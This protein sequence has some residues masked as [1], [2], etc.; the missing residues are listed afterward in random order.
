MRWLVTSRPRLFLR[1]PDM[2]P[3]TLCSC[4]HVAA[5][6]SFTVA[7]ELRLKSCM[8]ASDFVPDRAVFAAPR[9][10]G[11]DFD[12][13]D[14]FDVT[15][16]FTDFGMMVFRVPEPTIGSPTTQS[17]QSASYRQSG[18]RYTPTAFFLPNSNAS[19]AGEVQSKTRNR[20]VEFSYLHQHSEVRSFACQPILH[21]R[22]TGFTLLGNIPDTPGAC[23][24]ASD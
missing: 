5:A 17:P 24:R 6:R 1:V 13:F 11:I 19:L 16:F 3:R 22:T 9:D 15:L 7:P 10:A 2:N 12:F 18:G 4:Q 23:G 21:A 14:G 20:R 8:M